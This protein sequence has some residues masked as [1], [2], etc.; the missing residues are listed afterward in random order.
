MPPDSDWRSKVPADKIKPGKK[1]VPKGECKA[2][3][4]RICLI[5][6]S[7]EDILRGNYQLQTFICSFCYAQM[8]NRPYEQSC[9]GKPTLVLLNGKRLLGYDPEAPECQSLCQ[10][11]DICRRIVFPEDVPV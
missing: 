6:H 10:D 11:R 7:R 8:Q 4:C 3:E 5:R 2:L 1:K 9:F